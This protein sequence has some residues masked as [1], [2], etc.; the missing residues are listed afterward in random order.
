MSWVLQNLCGFGIYC[1][2]SKNQYSLQVKG[3]HDSL[4]LNK[5]IL[6]DNHLYH[7]HIDC[8]KIFDCVLLYL[9][10]EPEPCPACCSFACSLEIIYR[11]FFLQDL[12][13]A[14][15]ASTAMYWL[16]AGPVHF[17]VLQTGRGCCVISQV[18]LSPWELVERFWEILV[19]FAVV[20]QLASSPYVMCIYQKESHLISLCCPIPD[21]PDKM[22]EHSV[23]GLPFPLSVK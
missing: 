14:S 12:N 15:F 21:S 16:G 8:W 20:A 5:N 23:V 1:L 3:I 18:H 6:Y 13:C 17:P 11:R 9:F 7:G 22:V 19:Q 2:I 4:G 10:H